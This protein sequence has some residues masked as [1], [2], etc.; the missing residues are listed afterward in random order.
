[1]YWLSPHDEIACAVWMITAASET[2]PYTSGAMNF[3]SSS[4][5]QRPTVRDPTLVEI[6]QTA[7]SVARRAS[8]LAA[9]TLS[10]GA[11]SGGRAPSPS[12]DRCT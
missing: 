9:P 1:M 5:P 4:V 10:T 7:P 11:C 12:S 6:V 3:V 8:G 2:S